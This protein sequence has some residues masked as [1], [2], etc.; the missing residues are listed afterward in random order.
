MNLVTSDGYPLNRL[1]DIVNKC[2]TLKDRHEKYKDGRMSVDIDKFTYD[3]IVEYSRDLLHLSRN[4]TFTNLAYLDNE[5][6]LLFTY[7]LPNYYSLM[8]GAYYLANGE[9][10]EKL[11]QTIALHLKGKSPEEVRK[12]FQ[13]NLSDDLTLDEKEE[14]FR[15]LT[16]GS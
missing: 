4:P 11:S 15:F 16:N 7:E 14:I 10:I 6:H 8:R 1:M 12:I 2:I 13:L 3:M 5:L 9:L